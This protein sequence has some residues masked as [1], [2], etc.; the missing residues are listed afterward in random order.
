MLDFYTIDE[1]ESWDC[2]DESR[3]VGSLSLEQHDAL[4][5]LYSALGWGVERPSYFSDRRITAEQI[6]SGLDLLKNE[7]R[8]SRG[9]ASAI[10][11]EKL[12]AILLSALELGRGIQTYCD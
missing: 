5:D 10:A 11:E 6:R 8:G 12:L 7:V 2:P 9:V 3:H 4:S 1:H